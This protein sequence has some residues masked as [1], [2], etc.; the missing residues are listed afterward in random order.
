MEKAQPAVNAAFDRPFPS[1][2]CNHAAFNHSC[3]RGHHAPS[4][5]AIDQIAGSEK[6]HVRLARVAQGDDAL[7]F[8]EA[9]E[10]STSNM[11]DADLVSRRIN[12]ARATN[13]RLLEAARF[14]DKEAF[15]ELS[16]RHAELVHRKVFGIVRNHEDTE[17]VVQEA[18]FKAYTH[19]SGFRGSC[20]FSTWLM[21]IAINSA[22]ML[23][24]K[25]GMHSEVSCDQVGDDNKEW[26]PWEFPDQHLDAERSYSKRQ[27]M[28]L[29]SRAIGGLP[30]C[31]RIALELYHVQ[32]ESMQQ[33]ADR[34]GLTVPAAKSRLMRGRLKLRASLAKKGISITDIYF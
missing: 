14:H 17:D 8:S 20:T 15:S 34:L 30:L 3:P 6:R 16:V 29:L 11:D 7:C 26:G 27:T 19:L 22:F 5:L 23:L 18:L 2:T 25:R 13:E 4:S 10:T 31:Y 24:R 28:D 9:T 1:T 21:R 33:T 32:E 12:Y